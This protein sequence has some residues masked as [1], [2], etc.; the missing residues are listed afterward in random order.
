MER[1]WRGLVLSCYHGLNFPVLWMARLN[2]VIYCFEHLQL[3]GP[4]SNGYSIV[5][6]LLAK[7]MHAI[8]FYKMGQTDQGNKCGTIL[9]APRASHPNCQ[10]YD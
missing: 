5:F 6:S 2:R 1:H 7:L 10:Y 8:C 3:A 9:Q 4:E